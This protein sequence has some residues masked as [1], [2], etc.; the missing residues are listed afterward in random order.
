M[1]SAQSPNPQMM[2]NGHGPGGMNSSTYMQTTLSNS[3]NIG[4]MN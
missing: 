2:Q 3:I 1:T 4:K